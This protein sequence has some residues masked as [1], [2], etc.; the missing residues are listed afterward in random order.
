MMMMLC[1]VA[2][3]SGFSSEGT[4]INQPPTCHAE[5]NGTWTMGLIACSNATSLGYTLFSPMPS[6]TSFLIDNHGREVHTWESPGG[7]RPGLS[8]YLLE[9]GDLLRTANIAQQAVGDFSGGGTAG[10]IE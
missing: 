6:T 8:S 10:K 2:L 9:D 3:P 4:H 7:H 1:L 5:R